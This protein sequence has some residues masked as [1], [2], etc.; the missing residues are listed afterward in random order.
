MTDQRLG[1]RSRNTD[2]TATPTAG[3]GT[4]GRHAKLPSSSAKLDVQKTVDRE[5]FA[6]TEKQTSNIRR[7]CAMPRSADVKCERYVAVV[8][9]SLL[10]CLS[11][12]TCADQP[13]VETFV[14]I[15]DDDDGKSAECC[16]GDNYVR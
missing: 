11:R 5:T 10:L 7:I 2:P 15:G 8:T 14:I 4:D 12:R 3:R 13:M 1:N 9:A 16:H 6:P